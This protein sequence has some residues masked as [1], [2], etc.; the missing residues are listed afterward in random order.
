RAAALPRVVECHECGLHF[1]VGALTPGTAAVCSRCGATMLR[2]PTNSLDRTLALA[3]AGLV[4]V[5]VANTLPFM[6]LEISGRLQEANLVTGAAAL[7]RDGLWSLGAVVL[8]TT[9]VAPALKLGSIVYVLVGLRLRRPPR[10][11]PL[12]CRLVVAMRPWAM[13]EVYLLGV[14]VAYVKL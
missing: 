1:S 5:V 12:V 8:L 11:L 9:I 3:L 4:L 2:A 7:F 10:D 13:V 6:A 14:F